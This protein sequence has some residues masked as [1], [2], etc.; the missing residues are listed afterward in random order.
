M[1]Q[2]QVSVQQGLRPGSYHTEGTIL[3]SGGAMQAVGACLQARSGSIQQYCRAQQEGSLQG[4]WHRQE[5]APWMTAPALP[6]GKE[7][8]E[9]T[10][11]LRSN[12]PKALGGPR[13]A[14]ILPLPG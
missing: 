14:D 11:M 6:T 13:A 10:W 4:Y 8:E 2:G 7:E 12:S 1:G 9:T 5:L 3:L